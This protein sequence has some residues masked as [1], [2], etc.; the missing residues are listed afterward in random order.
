[1]VNRQTGPPK[2]RERQTDTLTCFMSVASNQRRIPGSLY[3]VVNVVRSI[4]MDYKR[5]RE[6]ETD[7]KEERYSEGDTERKRE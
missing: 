5:G 2:E 6:E 7:R 3:T 4:H 1:M